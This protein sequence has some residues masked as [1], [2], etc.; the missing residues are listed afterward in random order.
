MNYIF[1]DANHTTLPSLSRPLLC[2]V[3]KRQ[4]EGG[5]KGS[6][7]QRVLHRSKSQNEIIVGSGNNNNDDEVEEGS[8]SNNNNNSSSN[9]SS[10][11]ATPAMSSHNSAV[12]D[13][14]LRL[15]EAS[16]SNSS[17]SNNNNNSSSDGGG[18][19]VDPSSLVEPTEADLSELQSF[20]ESGDLDHLDNMVSEFAKQYLPDTELAT[21]AANGNTQQQQQV[22]KAS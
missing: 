22:G 3:E 15:T 10:S 2:Q 4:K 7:F 17:G 12:A 21:E 13:D 14:A 6:L 9:S 1:F 20:L 11:Q 19:N 5:G 8:N 18:G 16:N